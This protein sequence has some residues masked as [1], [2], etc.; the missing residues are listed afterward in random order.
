[1]RRFLILHGLE[2]HRPRGHWQWWLT[3]ELRRCGEQALYPQLPDPSAPQLGRWLELL[4]AE[5]EQ[6]GDGERV[7]ICHSLACVLWYEA[8]R[9]KV[10]AR[11]ADR[12]LLVAPPGPSVIAWPVTADFH[13]GSWNGDLLR[14][15]SRS[16][17]RLVASER[18]PYC[19]EG[20]AALVWGEPLGLDAETIS[21]A[22]HFTITDGY[23]PWRQALRWCLDG[24][25]RFAPDAEGEGVKMNWRGTSPKH[26]LSPG[27]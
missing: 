7:V 24:T 22:G 14:A 9:R 11:P 4:S 17:I 20:P 5:Y 19:P 15:S 6:L 18:D 8:C 26:L 12:I 2:N 16:S 1:M 25:V 3:E 21:A 27:C 23:G 13:Q 10:L